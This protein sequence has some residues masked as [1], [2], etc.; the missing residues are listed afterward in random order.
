MGSFRPVRCLSDCRIDG[1]IDWDFQPS[2]TTW[3][4]FEQGML[5]KKAVDKIVVVNKEVAYIYL[6]RSFAN[7]S[8]FTNDLPSPISKARNEGPHYQMPIGSIDTFERKLEKAQ[9][10]FIPTEKISVAYEEKQNYGSWL[11]WIL[12]FA[13][14][15]FIFNSIRR[16]R[17]HGGDDIF[18]FW[19]VNGTSAGQRQ[20]KRCHF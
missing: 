19:A 14:L 1:R 10:E 20:Q 15:F 9:E 16:R 3:N 12:P 6:K 17:K 7:D 8:S 18:K 2:E 13:I 11:V 5:L 4:Q